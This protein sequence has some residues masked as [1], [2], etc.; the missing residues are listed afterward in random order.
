MKDA[1][2]VLFHGVSLTVVPGLS[3]GAGLFA[4]VR[5]KASQGCGRVSLIYLDEIKNANDGSK[6]IELVEPLL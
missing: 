5:Q 1:H 2:S 6:I 4:E 3:L